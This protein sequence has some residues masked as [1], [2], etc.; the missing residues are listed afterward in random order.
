MPVSKPSKKQTVE[1][2]PSRIR[3]DP[4]RASAAEGPAAKARWDPSE[5]ETWIVVIGVVLFALAIT[6]LS[7]GISEVTSH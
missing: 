3:R 6:A 5:R 1:L 4:V 2:K 7:I